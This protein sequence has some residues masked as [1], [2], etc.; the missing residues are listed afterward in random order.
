[1]RIFRPLEI[2]GSSLTAHRLWMELIS[3]NM[4]NAK[5]PRARPRVGRTC[6]KSPYSQSAW[7]RL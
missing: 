1:M 4:A 3:Q 6:A 5:H 2:A 7:M